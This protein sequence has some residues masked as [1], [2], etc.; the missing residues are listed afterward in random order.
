MKKIKLPNQ[1]QARMDQNFQE[2]KRVHEDTLSKNALIN[3]IAEQKRIQ[4]E[5]DRQY[6]LE[7]T[8]DEVVTFNWD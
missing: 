5:K 2:S 8:G 7:N 3:R 1:I 4:A 6:D